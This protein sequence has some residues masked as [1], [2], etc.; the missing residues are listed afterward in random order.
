MSRYSTKPLSER[1]GLR[2]YQRLYFEGAPLIYLDSL[3]PSPAGIRFLDTPAGPIDFIHLFVRTQAELEGRIPLLAE[4]L[5]SRGMLWVSW[6]KS[7]ALLH[8]GIDDKDVARVGAACGLSDVKTCEIDETWTGRKLVFRK[9]GRP[10]SNGY[11]GVTYAAAIG[12][13]DRR[14]FSVVSAGIR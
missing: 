14:E 13:L 5:S 12:R 2:P 4:Q 6:L 10:R 1:L 7:R 9:K 3:G 8:N 11:A